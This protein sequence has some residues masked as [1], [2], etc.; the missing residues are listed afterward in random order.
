[1]KRWKTQRYA[2]KA[3]ETHMRRF[4]TQSMAHKTIYGAWDDLWRVWGTLRRFKIGCE[5]L[6]T[7]L[8]MVSRLKTWRDDPEMIK[9][10]PELLKAIPS[11]QRRSWEYQKRYRD[12]QRR[13]ER[14]KAILWRSDTIQVPIMIRDAI[15]MI[16]ED[17]TPI[18]R[19][20]SQIKRIKG[21]YGRVKNINAN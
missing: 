9:G 20:V 2:C 15:N 12:D 10:D 5:L 4:D 14:S 3:L 21:G 7:D 13:F 17:W 8:N 18:I 1:M 16:W 6:E 11:Y 19:F